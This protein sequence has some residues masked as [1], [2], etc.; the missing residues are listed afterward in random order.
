VDDR[1]AAMIEQRYALSAIL[2]RLVIL[3]ERA[4]PGR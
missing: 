4:A 3:F 2:P 1:A